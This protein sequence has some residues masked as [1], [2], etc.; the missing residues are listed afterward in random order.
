MADLETL[1]I[2]IKADATKAY[3][4][5]DKLAQSIGNLSTSLA[6]LEVGKLNQLASGLVSLNTAI[7][8]VKENSRA[9]DYTR[10]AKELNAIGSVNASGINNLATSLT[11]LMASLPNVASITTFSADV[12]T[13]SDTI[14]LLGAAKVQ[15]AISNL[16]QL[17]QALTHLI[18][19]ISGLP[20]INQSI[21]EFVNSLTNLAAQGQHMGTAVKGID[22][23]LERFGTTAARVTRKT[24]SLASTIGTLYAKFWIFLRGARALKDSFI[25]AADYL[26]A[27]N[28]FDVTAKKIGKDTFTKAGVG[29]AE[30]YAQAFVDTLQEKLHKMSGLELDL[31]SRLI[32]TT[33][34]K[35]LG[36][37]LTELTQYQ[38]SIASITNAMGASQEIAQSTAKA[39]SMLAGDMGSLK[40]LDF[41]QVSQNLQSALTGQARALYKYGIDLTSATLEQYAYANGITKSVSEM[42]QAEKAQLR[43]LAILDQSKVAWGDLANTINSPSNQLR[44]LQNNLKETGVVFGQLF[45]PIMS[46]ALPVI[47]GLSMAIKQLMVDI[48]ELLGIQ[49][50][51]ESFGQFGD[52]IDA[53]VEGM[54]D[55]NKA[56]EKTKK[57]IREFDELKVI[58]SGKGSS[59]DVGDQ[60]DLTKEI[61][62][63]TAEYEKVW[64]EAYERM[65]SKASEIAGYISQAFEPIKTI[66]E[67]FHIG[68][69][70]KAGE[71]VSALVVSIF[72]FISD[73]ISQVDWKSLGKKIGDFL[74]GLNWTEILKSLGGLIASAIQGAFDV[75]K[76][77]FSAAPF[78]TA[79]ITAFG[80]LKFTGLGEELKKNLIG[81]ITGTIK[82]PK[83]SKE[84]LGK[85][86]A[87]SLGIGIALTID[88]VTSIKSGAYAANDLKAF[89]KAGVSSLFSGIGVSLLAKSIGFASGAMTL[90]VIGAGLSLGINL[91][92]MYANMET[93]YEQAR[94]VYEEE[95]AWVNEYNLNAMEIETDIELR[96][97]ITQESLDNI[98]DLSQKV[99][100]LSQNYDSLTDAQ[101]GQLKKYSD[102][103]VA[104]VPGAKGLIDEMTGAWKGTGD[105]LQR[106]IDLEKENIRL[107]AYKQNLQDVK[108]AQASGEANLLTL[109]KDLDETLDKRQEILDNFIEK[110]GEEKGKEYYDKVLDDIAN[111]RNPDINTD[112]M[113]AAIGISFTGEKDVQDLI[114]DLSDS[115]AKED[116]LNEKISDTNKTLEDLAKDFEYWDEHVLNEY[117]ELQ[118]EAAEATQEGIDTAVNY[119]G[120]DKLPKSIHDTLQK[121]DNNI[122]SDGAVS[123]Q[124][125][126]TLF[127]YINTSFDG[128]DNGEVPQEIQRTMAAIKAAITTNSPELVRYM[129]LLKMQMEEAF[130][131]AHYTTNGEVLWNPNDI[132]GK[133][134]KDVANIEEA[135]D[136]SAKPTLTSLENHLH[137]LFG[138]NLPDEVNRSFEYL[139]DTIK[140][141]KGRQDIMA[142]L[143]WLE[144]DV[145]NA[146]HDL[147]MN[148]EFGI[149]G[150]VYSG[151]S[152]VATATTTMV[153]DGLITPYKTET[154]T[155]SPSKVFEKLAEGVPEGAA[156]GIKEATPLTVRAIDTMILQMQSAFSGVKFGIPTLDFLNGNSRGS[157]DY[158]KMDSNN[159]FMSQMSGM[160]NQMAQN[161]QTEVVFRIEGDPYGMF[162]IV[163][164]ENDKY[165]RMHSNRSA[166][167]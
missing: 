33:N 71:D 8:Q 34:A 112:Y 106:V 144:N 99:W 50:D 137:E 93:P 44:M 127:S 138:E 2:Q 159:A 57:G 86:G 41:E 124:D 47:N 20:Q 141:G 113:G 116:E 72:D 146:G 135:L 165:K 125:M 10:M 35:S 153:Q 67:D 23:S 12:K 115:V 164:E 166:F 14:G 21:I 58:S 36:L 102:E 147:G 62:D 92:V 87:V 114:Q 107:N 15:K 30:E 64:D 68:D 150:G 77:A 42:T 98:D 37:N 11:N 84:V 128:L 61:V 43:L 90:G 39:F 163:R 29:N 160:A 63:A 157:F 82:D 130:V 85:L 75:W 104:L 22:T 54:E 65:T 118:K 32:K 142:A 162:K 27:F 94:K 78:E 5:I 89:L 7:I 31:E 13:L 109:Q 6:A 59:S 156:E 149:A 1:S 56:V 133:L 49:L 145:V 38:A 105:E 154:K 16:P 26:E 70:F 52:E 3:K 51:L 69:F 155:N 76:G 167:T 96:G 140:S 55:L 19:S 95:Y 40:N 103:L 45:I 139:A 53:D 101:K 126:E 117:I 120:K 74:N 151:T 60:I 73:A 123:K 121:V 122:K 46:S 17:E 108:E 79:I 25:S 48:A 158:G 80:I 97:T 66:I 88:N 81:K 83:I 100:D 134:D 143:E 4:A 110:F 132:S 28:Y 161:G 119:L 131:N 148:L 9:S 91:A 136:H 152:A 129:Q 111:G 24:H 18:Q